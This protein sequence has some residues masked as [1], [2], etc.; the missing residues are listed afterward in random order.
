MIYNEIIRTNDK[1]ISIN[2]P[3]CS[4]NPR[5]HQNVKKAGD[6][7][8]SR[9]YSSEKKEFS[10]F[11]SSIFIAEYGTS[12]V[13]EVSMGAKMVVET[14]FNKR[15][16]GVDETKQRISCIAVI[17]MFTLWSNSSQMSTFNF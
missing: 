17:H 14:R 5:Y 7:C 4:N 8:K 6:Q 12:Y 10:F 16:N 1:F 15:A 11:L 2:W 9:K 13:E 3:F